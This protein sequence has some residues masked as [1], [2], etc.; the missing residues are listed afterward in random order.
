MNAATKFDHVADRLIKMSE[1][2][3]ITGLSRPT[4]YRRMR[5]GQFPLG[6]KPG[7]AETRWLESEVRDWLAKTLT[8]RTI[9]PA[10]D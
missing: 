6:I 2:E 9:G 7:G 5:D 3:F 10:N 4:I 1:V 8:K